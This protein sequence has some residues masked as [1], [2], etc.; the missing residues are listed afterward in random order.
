M[1]NHKT[2]STKPTVVL[3]KGHPIN[4]K[5]LADKC[6]RNC[7][8]PFDGLFNNLASVCGLQPWVL[9]VTPQDEQRISS[10]VPKGEDIMCV[11]ADGRKY[12]RV[13]KDGTCRCLDQNTGLCIIYEYRPATCRAYP[14]YIDKYCGLKIDTSCPGVGEGWTEWDEIRSILEALLDVYQWQISGIR[15]IFL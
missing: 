9:P 15:E 1:R 6:P 12:L 4:W 11:L 8:T 2:A 5:C 13:T 7:C 3:K 14:F 10:G